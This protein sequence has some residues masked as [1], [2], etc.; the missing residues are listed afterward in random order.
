MKT[1]QTT[2]FSK[3]EI[4]HGMQNAIYGQCAGSLAHQTLFGSGML[5]LFVLHLSDDAFW[6]AVAHNATGLQA[7]AM[8]IAAL[9]LRPKSPKNKMLK[10]YRIAGI[11]LLLA[12]L[13]VFIV[14][15]RSL[16]F[17]IILFAYLFN[18]F[19]GLGTTYWFPVLQD[20]IPDDFRGRFFARLRASWTMLSMLV[21]VLISQ[22]IH[23]AITRNIFAMV[24]IPLALVYWL[25]NYFFRKMPELHHSVREPNGAPTIRIMWYEFLKNHHFHWFLVYVACISFLIGSFG[26]VLI[27]Y[28]RNIIKLADHQ[29]MLL[30]ILG[31][32]GAFGAFLVCGFF[33]D[34]VRSKRIFFF[35][36]ALMGVSILLAG[37]ISPHASYLVWILLAINI[38]FR[39]LLAVHGVAATSYLFH[40][41]SGPAKTLFTALN[42][43]AGAT[44]LMLSN[45]LGGW[46][47]RHYGDHSFFWLG[48]ELTIY[49]VIFL[50]SGTLLILTL[51]L[52]RT[53]ERGRWVLRFR[54]IPRL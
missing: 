37:L 21:V 18:I 1:Q 24:I 49:Q 50:A 53:V 43:L 16:L 34:K 7:L 4:R 12:G 2:E 30:T 40:L 38:L 54:K 5:I 35:A 33:I 6:A 17:L 47:I 14:P 41:M 20:F 25:R 15:E 26:P 3:T 8:F 28:L 52:I 9:F 48:G 10:F 42:S 31:S 46:L 51:P 27:M 29:N 19:N 11:F 44:M 39:S 32:I 45:F 22:I 23:G 13:S 36:Q